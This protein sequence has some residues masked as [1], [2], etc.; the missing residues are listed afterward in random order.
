MKSRFSICTVAITLFST[1]TIPVGLAAQQQ[2]VP[3]HHYKLIDLGTSGRPTRSA[4]TVFDRNQVRYSLTVL[5]TLG[6][7][8]WGWK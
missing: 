1:L 8:K 6:G 5:D 7:T 4:P 2:I 3:D